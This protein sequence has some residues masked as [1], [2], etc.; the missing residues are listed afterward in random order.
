MGGKQGGAENA[1]SALGWNPNGSHQLLAAAVG[2]NVVLIVT[3]T[4]DSDA[5]EVTETL[6]SEA[7][8]QALKNGPIVTKGA[9]D[10]EDD[11]DEEEVEEEEAEEEDEEDNKKARKKIISTWHLHPSRNTSTST[12]KGKKRT[13]AE[14]SNPLGRV[15]R[16]GELVGPR[17]TLRLLSKSASGKGIAALTKLVWHH[18]GDHRASAQY[19]MSI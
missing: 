9:Q 15:G 8:E 13:P 5:S 18:K 10:K 1:I 7:E 12:G 11:E 16:H 2:S 3:G 4:G 19:A 14:D 6:L 17:L